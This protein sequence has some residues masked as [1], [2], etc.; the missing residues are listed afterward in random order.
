M[1]EERL[2][3]LASLGVQVPPTE[4][5]LPYSD[6]EPM[7]SERHVLQMHLLIEP[8]RLHWSGRPDGYVGGNMFVYFSLEQTRGEHFRG[9]DF[10][11]VL[12]VPKRERKSWVVWQE[13]K[14]PDVIV[15]LLSASTASVDKGEK[16]RIYQ[17]ELR[18]PEYYWYDPFSAELAGFRLSEG[19]Y[20]PLKPDRQGCLKSSLLG[21]V[22]RRWEGVYEDVPATWLRWATEDGGLL[23]TRAEQER[24]RAEQEKARAE[25]AEA[26]ASRAQEALA[27]EHEARR[28][29][30]AELAALRAGGKCHSK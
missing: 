17:D 15:E 2:A 24:E 8:L 4:D 23:P 22:L 28:R 25:Q 20:R 19:R 12:G 30:E 16:K 27:A 18:V 13:G 3:E 7:E 5:E 6:G 26:R 10:F 14:G 29:L 21:L 1:T 11:A 9:P